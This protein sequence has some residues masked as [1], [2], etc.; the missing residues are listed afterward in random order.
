MEKQ[1]TAKR[2]KLYQKPQVNQV[3]LMIQEAVLGVCKVSTELTPTVTCATQLP[4][5]CN[6]PGT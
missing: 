2:H 4:G 5:Q 1:D 6:V 3:K